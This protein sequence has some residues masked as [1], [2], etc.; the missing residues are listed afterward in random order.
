MISHHSWPTRH[1]FRRRPSPIQPF[2]LSSAPTTTIRLFPAASYEWRR[3]MTI[4]S[5]PRPLASTTSSSSDLSSAKRSCWY[6]LFGHKPLSELSR[7]R[8]LPVA[9]K[10]LLGPFHS[11][12]ASDSSKWRSS[13]LAQGFRRTSVSGELLFQANFCFLLGMRHS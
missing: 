10:A 8:F 13:G 3:L 4:R 7:E 11:P 12:M 6:S 1:H 9:E 5:R 2:S